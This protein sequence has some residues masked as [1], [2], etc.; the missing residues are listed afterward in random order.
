MEMFV[1]PRLFGDKR[2]IDQARDR[3]AT[4]GPRGT[5]ADLKGVSQS[6]AI[7]LFDGE[8]RKIER[9]FI[10]VIIAQLTA[11][12]WDSGAESGPLLSL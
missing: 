2:H 8:V 11:P 1:S 6:E 5:V 9:G 3:E 4:N 7:V 12:Q 10:G